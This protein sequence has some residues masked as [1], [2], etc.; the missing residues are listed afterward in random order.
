MD[1]YSINSN[2]IYFVSKG[3]VVE[4]EEEIIKRPHC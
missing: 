4:Q 3:Q 2:I 1:V